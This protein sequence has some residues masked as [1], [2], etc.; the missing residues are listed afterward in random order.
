[1]KVPEL[2][3]DAPALAMRLIRSLSERLANTNRMLDEAKERVDFLEK[4]TRSL[5]VEAGR[6]EPPP[7]PAPV[8]DPETDFPEAP[9][10]PLYEGKVDRPP[11]M[12]YRVA[13]LGLDSEPARPVVESFGSPGEEPAVALPPAGPDALS[14][15]RDSP[16]GQKILERH[17]ADLGDHFTVAGL[18]AEWDVLPEEIEA[19]LGPFRAAGLIT[20]GSEGGFFRLPDSRELWE[21]LRARAG[22]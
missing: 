12:E 16:L 17:W 4:R 1:P 8:L 21:A 20:L 10:D 6:A 9:P 14:P 19:A 7:P 3:Q 5:A 13:D 2:L 11:T 18:T 22:E 15:F